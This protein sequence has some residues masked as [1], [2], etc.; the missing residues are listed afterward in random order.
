MSIKERERHPLARPAKRPRESSPATNTALFPPEREATLQNI[1]LDPHSCGIAFTHASVRV[2]DELMETLYCVMW[3]HHRVGGGMIVSL[4]TAVVLLAHF[5]DQVLPLREW[6][7]WKD[8]VQHAAQ[9]LVV[10]QHASVCDLD[11]LIE[12]QHCGGWRHTVSDT[13]AG[14]R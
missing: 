7:N 10:Q 9:R 11:D 3:L 8:T 4:D 2:L 6:R 14:I 1:R 12:P 5:P 13:F